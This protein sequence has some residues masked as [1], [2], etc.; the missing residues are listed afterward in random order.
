[1]ADTLYLL[2]FIL[3]IAYFFTFSATEATT[4]ICD[5]SWRCV[6][7]NVS[8]ENLLLMIMT[9]LKRLKVDN[10]EIK[11]DDESPLGV[12]FKV[13]WYRDYQEALDSFGQLYKGIYMKK[14]ARCMDKWIND[15]QFALYCSSDC[16]QIHFY[17]GSSPK[18]RNGHLC[19]NLRR[20]KQWPSSNQTP[21]PTLSLGKVLSCVW[22]DP[23]GIVCFELLILGE[24]VTV[25]TCIANNYND[26]KLLGRKAALVDKKR[27]AP[28]KTK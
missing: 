25:Q 21:K 14:S 15:K 13:K 16:V 28:T 22:W 17:P 6:W 18:T 23:S 2:R 26:F 10:V 27:D 9:C 20:S 24:T 5:I 7:T 1:M 4:E 12:W 11:F 19:D 3:V 8:S